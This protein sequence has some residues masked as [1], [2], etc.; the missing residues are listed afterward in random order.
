M[1]CLQRTNMTYLLKYCV[2][3]LYSTFAER[4]HGCYDSLVFDRVEGTG[5]VD[6]TTTGGQ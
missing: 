1:T 6:Q 2:C 4:E 5:G 3:V